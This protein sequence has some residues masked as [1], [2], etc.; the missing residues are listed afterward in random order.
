MKITKNYLRQLIRE[1]LQ[2]G[3]DHLSQQIQI[4]KAAQL[5]SRG[6]SPDPML[7]LTG[8]DTQQIINKIN[9]E[10]QKP[11]ITSLSKEMY[12]KLLEILQKK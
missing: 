2:E 8:M 11:N 5:A 12:L 1:N 10:L 9:N 7:Q 3:S 6:K 4:A